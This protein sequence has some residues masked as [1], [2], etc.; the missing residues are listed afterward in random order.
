MSAAASTSELAWIAAALLSAA[1][2]RYFADAT[3]ATNAIAASTD[4]SASV[5][6]PHR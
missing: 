6:G 1:P 3:T 2:A 4:P 5:H